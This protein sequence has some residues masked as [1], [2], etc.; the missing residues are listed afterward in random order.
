MGKSVPIGG[1]RNDDPIVSYCQRER[2]HAQR[3]TCNDCDPAIKDTLE[4]TFDGLDGGTGQTNDFSD[5]EG[6]NE[7]NWLTT[8]VWRNQDGDVELG[9][10]L[11]VGGYWGIMIVPG[12]LC[13]KRW[14]ATVEQDCAPEELSYVELDEV[15]GCV[16]SE[17]SDDNSCVEAE[18]AT[19]AV[20]IP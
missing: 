18:G 3:A 13:W 6:V 20:S 5:F 7:V 17:C 9:H 19:A 10:G 4:I 12:F 11:D 16:D 2:L 8:C 1:D 14:V 15:D